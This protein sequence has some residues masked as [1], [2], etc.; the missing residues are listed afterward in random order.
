MIYIT[1]YLESSPMAYVE[2]IKLFGILLTK[3]S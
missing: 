2:W 3:Q 1:E